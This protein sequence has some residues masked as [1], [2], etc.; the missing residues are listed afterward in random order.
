ML[1]ILINQNFILL[2]VLLLE[3]AKQ[4]PK[5]ENNLLLQSFI[6]GFAIICCKQ[7]SLFLS[8]KMLVKEKM[9]QN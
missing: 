7:N 9:R 6:S 4:I 3:Y 2:A 1:T 5:S 8:H